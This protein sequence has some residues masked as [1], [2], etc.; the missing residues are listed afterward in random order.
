[1]LQYWRDIREIN[2]TNGGQDNWEEV[3]QWSCSKKFEN[4]VV[5]LKTEAVA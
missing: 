2:T 5:S 4:Y 3:K 1:M